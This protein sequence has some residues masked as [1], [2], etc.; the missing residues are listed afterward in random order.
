MIKAGIIG[1]SSLTSGEIIKILLNHKGVKL[2]YLES[3]HFTGK[4]VW[5]I[6]KFLKGIL[7]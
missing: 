6:H 7:D 5:E 4:K 2:T 3:E 1:T